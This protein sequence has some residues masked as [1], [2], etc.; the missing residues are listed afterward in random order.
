MSPRELLHATMQAAN[1]VRLPSWHSALI[2]TEAK[3]SILNTVSRGVCDS[4]TR[5]GKTDY[6]PVHDVRIMNRTNTT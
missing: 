1:E 3:L 6:K 5:T 2:K 4:V